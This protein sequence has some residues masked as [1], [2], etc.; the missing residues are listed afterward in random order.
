MPVV[1]KL[2][3]HV[4]FFNK[5]LE[6]TQITQLEEPSLHAPTMAEANKAVK[7]N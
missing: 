2:R 6:N 4:I 5:Y 1:G 7:R 3:K